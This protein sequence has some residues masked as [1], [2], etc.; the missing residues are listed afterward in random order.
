MGNY[1]AVIRAVIAVYLLNSSSV[2][3]VR[4]SVLIFTARRC[5][6]L[7]GKYCLTRVLPHSTFGVT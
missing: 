5:A 4:Q 2:V 3:T 1:T 7:Q 6:D